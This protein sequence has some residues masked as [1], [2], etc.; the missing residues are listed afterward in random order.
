[1]LKFVK[2]VFYVG[3]I[4]WFSYD[5]HT[6]GLPPAWVDV[7]EEVAANIKRTQVKMAELVKA[8]AKA[9]TPSFIDGKVDQCR[10]E[11][12]TQEITDLLRKSEKRLQNLSVGGLSEDSTV[13]RNVQVDFTVHLSLSDNYLP[14]R[15]W[16][17]LR[18]VDEML[19]LQF[20]LIL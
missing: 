14:S 12:L 4:S 11:D 8:H 7:S 9:L 16:F 13:K 19:N 17:N 20:L 1:M 6:V 2:R 15:V 18:D 10:I 3:L 5:V